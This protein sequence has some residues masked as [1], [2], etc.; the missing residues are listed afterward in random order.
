MTCVC[1][2]E[3]FQ[4]VILLPK[5]ASNSFKEDQKNFVQKV[6]PKFFFSRIKKDD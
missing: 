4:L 6:K 2:T 5:N 1:N 3:N